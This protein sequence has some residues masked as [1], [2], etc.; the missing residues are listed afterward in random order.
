MGNSNPS[1]PDFIGAAVIL[2][3]VQREIFSPHTGHVLDIRD[4]VV[5]DGSDKGHGMHV[6]TGAEYD[7]IEAAF[8]E[9]FPRDDFE[10]FDG[11]IING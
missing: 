10:V 5:I 2:F 11:R 8:F 3:M 9:H 1:D 4:A 6:M 7:A